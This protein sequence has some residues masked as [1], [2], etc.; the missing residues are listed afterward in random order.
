MKVDLHVSGATWH[1]D[2]PVNEWLDTLPVAAA[3]S[4]I[5]GLESGEWQAAQGSLAARP[6]A[7]SELSEA[8]A[9]ALGLPPAAPH[10]L[11]IRLSG[12]MGLADCALT[13]RW[14][15]PGR[16]V[17][18][19]NVTQDGP[20]LVVDAGRW[21]IAHPAL[22]I[23][24]LVHRFN[25]SVGADLEQQFRHW[26]G[27]RALLGDDGTARLTDAFLAAFRVITPTAVTFSVSTTNDGH[28]QIAP[29]VL[30]SRPA[31]DGDASEHVRALTEADEALLA[32]RIDQLPE[33]ASAF[34]LANGTYVIVD[35]PVRQ[36]IAALRRLRHAPQEVRI[37]AA[38]QPDAVVREM[39]GAEGDEACVFIETDR[40]G[41]R[42]IDI[43]QWQ[44]PIVP[45]IKIPPQEWDAPI[46][47][48]V[49]ID[50]QDVALDAVQLA[51]AVEHIRSAMAAGQP[52]VKIGD[53]EVRAT[54]ANLAAL[55]QLAAE[56]S[57]RTGNRRERE[58]TDPRVLII[59]TNLERAGFNRARGAARPGVIAMPAGVRTT[60]K[61]HQVT[62]VQ[63]MQRHWVS[64][65]RGALMCDDMGLGKTFQ[66]LMF[67]RWVKEL[68]D[69]AEIPRQ[70]MLIVAPVGLLRNWEAEIALHLE[71]TGLGRVVRVYGDHARALKTGRHVD[72][73]A[74]L[75]ASAIAR[76]DLILANYEAVTEYQ[77]AFG[78][79]PFAV[80]V[81]DEAQRIKSPG[82]RVTHAVKGLNA[83]FML[84][85]TGTPVEN[86]LADLWC[87]ADA[88]QPGALGELKSFSAR[89]ERNDEHVE[90]LRDAVWHKEEEER[91]P[92]RL[93][94]RRLKTDKLEGL[95][96]KHVHVHTRNMPAPQLEAYVRALAVR[97][98]T[99]SS[100]TLGMIQDLRRISLHPALLT[101]SLQR[102]ELRVEDSA[103]LAATIDVLDGIA[104]QGEK[105]LIFLESLDLQEADQLPTLLAR[106]YRM[107]RNP[108]VINGSVSTEV[109]QTRVD[110]FQR[111]KGFD[112][113]LLSP[114]AGGVGLTLT[115]ANHVIHLSRWWNPAV[116]DQ[117]SDRVYR[118]GQT[119]PV[120]IHY[121]LAVMPGHEDRSFDM[122]LQRL[123]D[124]KRG[125]AA[126]LMAAPAFTDADYRSLLN[127]LGLDGAAAVLPP[128][129]EAV[130]G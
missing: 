87:I 125:L 90:E 56:V 51:S 76:G 101:P 26:A 14:L 117:C 28:V 13:V 129:M 79:V 122:Q 62:G 100:G 6:R 4:V 81:L 5:A 88:V 94:L 127:G 24:E 21:R 52:T 130:D 86:R 36:A 80:T 48:G 110:T 16:T 19:R 67:C 113:M 112:V 11:D 126:S 58:D 3:A 105:A 128:A 47:S 119:R 9:R 31:R 68:M 53:A 115:A 63:W 118:I 109:R 84:A 60:P 120:H 85:M 55:E 20:W 124:R 43:G 96:P 93:V 103:R 22:A 95:P 12:R 75:D 35:E 92:P 106:R 39:L 18:A 97:N 7:I 73:T 1:L 44:P 74:R 98:L 99:G 123:M 2:R 91:G 72:G 104:E 41:D 108:M 50:G 82:A 64:G 23:I 49:R 107:R 111:E 46:E 38:R 8:A 42:V 114:K 40:F 29:V 17:T 70:P 32:R 121:P 69:S 78:S 65:S 34:P 61:P 15:Q 33:G 71:G 25:A 27:I 102:E 45:W 59:E 57:R 66:A 10:G 37:R 77:L 54:P 89:Y 116:E 30:V 83:G